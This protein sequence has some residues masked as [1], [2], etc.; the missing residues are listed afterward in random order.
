M[1]FISHTTLYLLDFLLTLT[2]HIILSTSAGFSV[3]SAYREIQLGGPTS[4]GGLANVYQKTVTIDV[5]PFASEF[6]VLSLE[7]QL[8]KLTSASLSFAILTI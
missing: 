4:D 7:L 2:S 8:I 5:H 3:I 1:I 6:Q